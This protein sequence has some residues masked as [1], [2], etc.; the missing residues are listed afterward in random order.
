MS[1]VNVQKLSPE[2]YHS[3]LKSSSCVSVGWISLFTQ[4]LREQGC[5]LVY[6]LEE[7][8]EIGSYVFLVKH[9]GDWKTGI[10]FSTNLSSGDTDEA[11]AFISPSSVYEDINY[12]HCSDFKALVDQTIACSEVNHSMGFKRKL[13][14]KTA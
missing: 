3:D 14:R 6:F 5:D 7:S 10:C 4:K 13:E 12:I 11:F 2:F 8:A 1:A 9:F